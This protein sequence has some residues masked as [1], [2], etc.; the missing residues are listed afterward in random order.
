MG[1]AMTEG[2]AEGMGQAA[3]AAIE[4]RAAAVLWVSLVLY[5]VLLLCGVWSLAASV[6]LPPGQVRA[7][8]SGA[9]GV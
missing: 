4:T 5:V 1:Q 3:A 9:A 7:V 8:S 6:L 2:M